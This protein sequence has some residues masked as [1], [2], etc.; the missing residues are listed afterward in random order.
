MRSTTTY[1]VLVAV[2][3]VIAVQ[4]AIAQCV[5]D[6]EMNGDEE[7][8]D[9][10][11]PSCD[12]ACTLVQ[13]PCYTDSVENPN[14]DEMLCQMKNLVGPIPEEVGGLTQLLKLKL[15]QKQKS[16]NNFET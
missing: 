11:G 13:H 3:S 14:G 16:A 4:H 6:G 12:D 7:G 10:G 2:A 15:L 1:L 9:C 8:V 5:V